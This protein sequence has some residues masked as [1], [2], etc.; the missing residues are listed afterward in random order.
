MFALTA[1]GHRV[2]WQFRDDGVPKSAMSIVTKDVGIV[3]D[4]ARMHRFPAPL[5]AATEQLLTAAIGAGMARFDDGLLI[6]LW[7]KFGLRI[8]EETGSVEEEMEKA[9]ELSITP[10]GTPIKVLFVGLG[11]MGA[12]MAASV[13]N[14]GIDVVGHDLS[15][16]A[17]ERF[18]AMGGKVASDVLEGAK[19]AEVAVLVPVTALQAEAILFGSGGAGGI[20]SVLPD[21]AVIV[22]CSTI[23]PSAAVR[24]Q[25]LLHKLQRGLKLVD[26]P[27]SGGPSRAN[28]GDLAVMASGESS[29]LE[30]ACKVL[31]AMSTQAGNTINLHF[32]RESLLLHSLTISRWRRIR[33]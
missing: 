33:Q 30:K 16:E 17:M 25:T 20:C 32:I 12:G 22:L 1:V 14:S 10:S 18:L 13:Q 24:I 28:I 19:G 23:A 11:A 3:M 26:A 21:N 8:P 2:P 27:M 9:R 31:Q 4:E 15:R 7:E 6:R 5:S 29:A